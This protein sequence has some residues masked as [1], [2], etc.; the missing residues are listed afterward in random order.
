MCYIATVRQ[1]DNIRK[2]KKQDFLFIKELSMCTS[3]NARRKAVYIQR[4][5]YQQQADKNK[6]TTQH[7]ESKNSSIF[8]DAISIK[9]DKSTLGKGAAVYPVERFASLGMCFV[10]IDFANQIRQAT[11]MAQ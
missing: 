4:G 5:T 11:I 2:I 10:R 3:I 7:N 1:K 9:C 8:R 6:N